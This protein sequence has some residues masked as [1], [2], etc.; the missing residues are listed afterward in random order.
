M[1]TDSTLVAAEAETPASNIHALPGASALRQGSAAP[2]LLI[3]ALTVACGSAVQSAFSP[4]QELTKL[5]MG[6]SDLQL[7]YTQGMAVAI[8]AAVL[9]IPLGWLVDHK[10]RLWLLIGMATLWTLGAFATVW[11]PNFE[12]MMAARMAAS[13]GGTCVLPIAISMAADMCRPEVRGRSLLLLTIGKVAGTALAFAIG[14]ALYGWLQSREI[15]LAGLVP[16]RGMHLIFALAS[17]ALI[18]PLFLLREPARREVGQKGAALGASLSALWARRGFLAPLFIGQISVIMADNAAVTWSA[19]VLSRTFHLSPD[20]FA[21]WLGGLLLGSGIL[22]A[23]IGGLASDIGHKRW[24]GK[25]ILLGAVICSVVAIPCALFSVMPTVVGFAVLLS[26]LLIAGTATGLM[27]ATA[28]AVLV[29]NEYRG[30]CLGAFVVVGVVFGFGVAPTAVTL[31][32]Q[33]LGGDGNLG[34]ALAIIGGVA[35]V[36]AAVAFFISMLAA[37][38]T[39]AG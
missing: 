1:A 21:G 9:S 29:P 11:A 4:V 19:S 25:G 10:T 35:A 2:T 23:V 12:V 34:M 7:S 30:L 14:G 22:G 13:L 20:Q 16:W 37:P 6:L 5:D 33:A 31:L 24:P 32:S 15:S 3:L 38:K 36:G 17:L 26:I 28:I 39:A 18:L 8:P 27:T